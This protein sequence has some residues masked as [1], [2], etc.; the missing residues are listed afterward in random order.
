MA[1]SGEVSS[2]RSLELCVLLAVAVL[3]IAGFVSLLVLESTGLI[4]FLECTSGISAVTAG[5]N[6]LVRQSS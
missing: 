2:L 1:G 6:G 3:Q 4:L 5:Q